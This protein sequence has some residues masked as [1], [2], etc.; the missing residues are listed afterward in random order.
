MPGMPEEP[1]VKLGPDSWV[2]FEDADGVVQ[3]GYNYDEH[4]HW[5]L[6]MD[7]KIRLVDWFIEQNENMGF[8]Y[9]QEARDL[10]ITA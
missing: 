2:T 1:L 9:C 8:H 6:L 5:F 4:V 7:G 10:E 3:I